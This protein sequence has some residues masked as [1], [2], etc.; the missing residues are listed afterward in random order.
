MSK[1]ICKR[2]YDCLVTLAAAKF[3]CPPHADRTCDS[4][5]CQRWQANNVQCTHV[6]VRYNGLARPAPKCL[7]PWGSGP[8]SNIWF[9]GPTPVCPKQHLDRFSH[10]CTADPCAQHTQRQ[11]DTQTMLHVTSVAICNVCRRCGLIIH[12]VI[13]SITGNVTALPCGTIPLCGP[14]NMVQI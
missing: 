6:H 8:S 14:S 5:I 13:A 3:I 1:V 9:L 7:F 2:P 10:F 11:T 4:H 12:T